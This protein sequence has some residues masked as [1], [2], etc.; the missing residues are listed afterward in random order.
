MEPPR[1]LPVVLRFA[2]A[3]ADGAIV[4]NDAMLG[5]PDTERASSDEHCKHA[6]VASTE[7]NRQ[8]NQHIS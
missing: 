2:S 6:P 7:A 5:D 8:V 1:H 4:R 3:A